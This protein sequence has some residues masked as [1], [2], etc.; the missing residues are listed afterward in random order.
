MSRRDV[1]EERL[2]AHL[3]D[4]EFDLVWVGPYAYRDH[5]LDSFRVGRVFFVGDSAHVVSPFGARGGNA[6]IQDAFNLGWKLALVAAGRAPGR[7]LDTYDS[8]RQPAAR[9]NLEVT[10][11][12]NRF[13][14]PRS[15]AERTARDA[16]IGLARRYP[17]ARALVNTGRMSVA[18]DYPPSSAL[19]QG[20][21]SLQNVAIALP[22]GSRST[23]VELAARVGTAFIGILHAP[24]RGHETPAFAWLE[25][26]GLPFRFFT[27]GPG[28]LGDPE[29]K[30]AAALGAAP[31]SF[32]L[33]RPDLYLAG[34][35]PD[36]RPQQADALLRRALCLDT[37]AA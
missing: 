31:G 27:C 20:G 11:R 4:I 13:L 12:T 5:L 22:D 10:T 26:T 15:R 28:G 8:E 36:A 21:R 17:F 9:E 23:L 16:V 19:P 18:N 3:G 29:G 35:I 14:A 34:C 32:A 2:R 30:L 24:T 25:A 6:G 33:I 7:L 37:V 1:A